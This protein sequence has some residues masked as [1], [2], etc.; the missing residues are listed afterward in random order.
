MRRRMPVML[1]GVLGALLFGGHGEAEA[2]KCP[3]ECRT[4]TAQVLCS[5][6]VITI[7]NDVVSMERRYWSTG[8]GM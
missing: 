1:A 6:T 2:A 8:G 5:T 4:E 3:S 7:G